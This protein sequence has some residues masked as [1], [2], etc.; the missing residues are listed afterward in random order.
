MSK[1]VKSNR[2]L[3]EEA[4][5]DK[6]VKFDND[7]IRYELLDPLM[8]EGISKVLTFGA[9]KYCDHNWIKCDSVMRY[10]GALMRHMWAWA[11][12]EDYDPETGIEHY[13]HAGCCLMFMIGLLRRNKKA[14]DRVLVDKQIEDIKIIQPNKPKAPKGRLVKE[15]GKKRKK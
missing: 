2:K 12:G 10:F 11:R 4:D 3:K 9:K 7:K 14:D 1:K 15:N 6:F 13:Y 8:L 5:F